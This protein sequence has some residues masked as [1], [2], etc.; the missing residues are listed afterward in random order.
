MTRSSFESIH[1]LIQDDDVFITTRRQQLNMR[2]QVLVTLH[3]LGTSGNGANLGMV[4]RKFDISEGSVINS[5]N[6][7]I[8]A[9]C[10]AN[11]PRFDLMQGLI[12]S[13]ELKDISDLLTECYSRRFRY[14]GFRRRLVLEEKL[15]FDRR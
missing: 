2:L 8:D 4:A 14:Q 6:R 1:S 5:T 13:L 11:I 3:R 10:K 12:S 15:V 7:I 9:L